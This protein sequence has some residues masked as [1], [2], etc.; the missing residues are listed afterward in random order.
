[1]PAFRSKYNLPNLTGNADD[2]LRGIY[3][4]VYS[5]IEELAYMFNNLETTNFGKEAN[6]KIK[7]LKEKLKELNKIDNYK[8]IYLDTSSYQNGFSVRLKNNGVETGGYI[9]FPDPLKFEEKTWSPDLG[10]QQGSAPSRT[11]YTI[12][13]HYYRIGNLVYVNCKMTFYI[14]STNGSYGT[15]TGL[16]YR[17]SRNW[18]SQSVSVSGV[19]SIAGLGVND[20]PVLSIAPGDN[21]IQ[22]R[23]GQGRELKNWATSGSENGYIAFSGTYFT[24]DNFNE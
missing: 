3:D 1:M 4:S 19:N 8:N 9:S 22:L 2:D 14:S 15:I 17:A 23:N 10:N 18:E 20:H 24:E 13:A 11:M 6:D 5:L 21:Y 16:P 12:N 7:E